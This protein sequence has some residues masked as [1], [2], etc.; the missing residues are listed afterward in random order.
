LA[1]K[2]QGQWVQYSTEQ[3]KKTAD[4][5]S[6]GLLHMGI[7]VG[8]KVAIISNNRPEWNFADMGILQTGAVNVPI[9]PTIS[10]H[11]LRFIL[12]DAEVKIV[13]V[14]SAEL[15][16]KTR[17]ACEGMVRPFSRSTK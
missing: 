13:F 2:D 16:S 11:D 14:S 10:D 3:F 5:V 15:E 6:Y 1:G 4:H 12:M 17:K 9:Y 8:D 7:G